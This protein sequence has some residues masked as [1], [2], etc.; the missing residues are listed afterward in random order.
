MFAISDPKEW[1]AGTKNKNLNWETCMTDLKVQMVRKI[2]WIFLIILE[3][4]ICFLDWVPGYIVKR[5][6]LH[7]IKNSFHV[8]VPVHFHMVELKMTAYDSYFFSVQY[9]WFH[10]Q[11]FTVF[12]FLS[13]FKLQY[14]VIRLP[15]KSLNHLPGVFPIKNKFTPKFP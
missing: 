5:K 7:G 13:N 2:I 3:I 10:P 8:H 6:A 11:N 15:I 4:W 1:R 12:T 14:S 9:E